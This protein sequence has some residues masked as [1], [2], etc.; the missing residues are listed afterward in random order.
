MSQPARRKLYFF[1]CSSILINYNVWITRR[2]TVY[3]LHLKTADRQLGYLQHMCTIITCS[4]LLHDQ[5]QRTERK[6]N[7]GRRAEDSR[8]DA[9]AYVNARETNLLMCTGDR[10]GLNPGPVAPAASGLTT[11]T[12]RPSPM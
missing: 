2:C 6:L 8:L 4:E 5:I 10:G 11:G 7:P 12:P 3:W 1:V 9:A